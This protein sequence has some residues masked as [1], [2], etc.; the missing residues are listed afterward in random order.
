[1]IDPWAGYNQGMQNLGQTFD[2]MQDRDR[3][4]A[5][6][7]LQDKLVN[8][9][10][11]TGQMA[12]DDK[13]RQISD[14]LALRT[15]LQTAQPE[16]T[17]S[18]IPAKPS[19]SAAMQ[20][21]VDIPG[22]KYSAKAAPAATDP[23][24][25]A[26]MQQEGLAEAPAADASGFSMPQEPASPTVQAYNERRIQT[27]TKEPNYHRIVLEHAKQ[28]GNVDLISKTN[29]DIIKQ[30]T[31]IATMTGSMADATAYVNNATGSNLK[32][33]GKKGDIE[34]IKLDNGA[35]AAIDKNK[36]AQG[37]TLPQ[38]T[39]TM[40]TGGSEQA[41]L[42][43]LSQ[44]PDTATAQD[45]YNL[46][47]RM[48]VKMEVA[49]KA[50]D[51]IRQQGQQNYKQRTRPDG[52]QLIYEE[53]N[54]GG[55]TWKEISRGDK[56]RPAS[57][58]IN[59]PSADNVETLAQMVASG[60]LDASQLPKRQ[61]LFNNVVARAKQINPQL[62]I[63]QSTADF[64]LAKNPQFRTKAITAETLPEVM[65]SMVEAGKRVGYSDVKLVG[66]LQKVVRGELNDPALVEY[67]AL[68]N[69]VLMTIASVMRGSGMTDMAHKAETEA[70]AP[71]M[72]PAAL[73]AWLRG[74]TKSLEPRLKNYRSITGSRPSAAQIKSAADLANKY[75]LR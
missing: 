23:G 57:I 36:L 62:N 58:N 7:L 49:N 26:D 28:I 41:F 54:D 15:K 30:A 5:A 52:R 47:A 50:V 25:M 31:N 74:Q 65:N 75:G 66:K 29:E 69:D 72:S 12:L 40:Q 61:G 73:D 45:I 16:T 22:S 13:R 59:A 3:K 4:R 38:A 55:K 32:Y 44:L 17:T 53:S 39:T 21:L 14:N 24:L 20:Q 8:Q 71:T 11:E 42:A 70:A 9:Q 46:G 48:G 34:I 51:N 56:D 27:T 19:Q 63:R 67:M 10:I 60:E 18:I 2:D 64:S 1:M 43:A 33:L 35:L 37:A 6:Q 68:R